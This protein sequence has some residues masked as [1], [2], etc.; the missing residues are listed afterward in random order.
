VD[1][2]EG[3][4]VTGAEQRDELLVGSEAQEWRGRV[5]PN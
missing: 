3:I 2:A 1:H 5:G 4:V